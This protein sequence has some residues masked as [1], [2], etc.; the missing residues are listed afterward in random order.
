[1][2]G[3]DGKDGAVGLTGKD[4]VTRTITITK[5]GAPGLDGKDGEVRIVYEDGE[6]NTHE[7]ATLDDGLKFGANKPEANSGNPVANKLN[8]TINI[9][10]EEPAEGTVYSTKNLTTT[11]D[12]DEDGNTTILVKMNRD[13]DVD[14]IVV[15]GKDGKDGKIGINGE[16]GQTT[17]ISVQTDGKPGLDGEDGITR[18][19]Y[20]DP[21]GND[22]DVA[23]LDDGLKYAGDFG[24]GAAV[25]LNNTVNVKGEA[26]NEEDLTDGNI[27]VVANQNANGKDAD[28]II[29]LNKDIDLTPDGSVTMGDTVINNDGLGRRRN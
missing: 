15:N 16:D 19:V 2:N 17:T 6:H 24:D 12:Q 25:K 13:L 23:T 14:T 22:H 9:L 21:E 10:G 3:K 1:M 8:S 29:K 11:V 7:V 4:G 18:I 26:E 5:D 28:L 27:G 20:K